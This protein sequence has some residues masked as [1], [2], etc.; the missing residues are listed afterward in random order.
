L[1]EEIPAWLDQ[2]AATAVPFRWFGDLT[3]A[4]VATMDDARDALAAWACGH[5]LGGDEAMA[6]GR[7]G[8]GR[9]SRSLPGEGLGI[10]HCRRHRRG[11]QVS[12]LVSSS[13]FKLGRVWSTLRSS[14]PKLRACAG[15]ACSRFQAVVFSFTLMCRPE[16]TAAADQ[17]VLVHDMSSTERGGSQRSGDTADTGR[18]DGRGP[19]GAA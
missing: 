7:G 3:T 12:C 9:S 11:A 10:A 14:G 17:H 4:E 13:A 8:R 2:V 19:V 15:G 5:R 6:N 18:F 1:A 16:G